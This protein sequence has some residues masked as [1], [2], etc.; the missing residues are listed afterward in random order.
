MVK[1]ITYNVPSEKLHQ[2]K[3]TMTTSLRTLSFVWNV[4]K[5]LVLGLGIA[6][7]IPGIVPFVNAYVYK[8]IIDFTVNAFNTGSF[9]EARLYILIG[10]RFITYF[11]QESAFTTQIHLERL[12]WTKVPISLNQEFFGKISRLD[13]QYFEDSKFRDLLEKVR[14]SYHFRPQQLISNLFYAMQS[15]TQVAIALI[16]VTQLSWW[17]VLLILIVSVPEFIIQ[18]AQSKNIWGIWAE[19]SPFRKR[20]WYLSDLLQDIKSIKEVKIFKLAGRFLKEVRD[21]QERFYRENKKVTRGYFRSNELYKIFTSITFIGIESFV[22]YQALNRRVTIGDIGFY[23]GVVSN[24]Q[25]GISGLFRNINRIFENSLYVKSIFEVLDAPPL[26]THPKTPTLLNL[27]GP[28]VIEFKN[29]DFLYPDTSRKVLSNFSLKI[30]AGQ[31]IAFVGENG[32]GKSTIIKLISR[33]YDPTKGEILINGIDLR[34]ADIAEWYTNLGVL[35]QDFNRY[36]HK[37]RE[38]ISFGN[39]QAGDATEKIIK[40]AEEAGADRVIERL[41]KG[42]DQLLGRIFQDGVELSSGQWQKIALARAFFKNAPVLILDEPTASIDARAE[43]EIFERVE[44]LVTDKTVIIVSHRF[45]TVR[46]ADRIYVIENGA[47]A[48]EGTHDDLMELRGRYAALFNL[49]AKGYK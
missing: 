32:A 2:I 39:V 24:F 28:P 38:N 6:M 37:V 40:A 20:F 35:F 8:L 7:L 42:Y 18:A 5:W 47:I 44:K 46:N 11:L 3:D 33:F 29:V 17:F 26:L 4:D 21:I 12:L 43:A 22:I 48:E 45:S 9:E 34:Q 30:E 14:D 41:P 1:F 15:F 10:L 13:V 25:N 49:Q 19:N 16:A 31:K 23:T 27:E 36:Q